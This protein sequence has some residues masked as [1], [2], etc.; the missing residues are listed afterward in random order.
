MLTFRQSFTAPA[1]TP[2]A[3]YF[4]AST[5]RSAVGIEAATAVAIIGPHSWF[6]A[7]M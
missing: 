5:M 2:A 6:W 1:V 7:P 4:W 3:T